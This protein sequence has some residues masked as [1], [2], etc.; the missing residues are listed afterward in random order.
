MGQGGSWRRGSG[1]A[2][3]GHRWVKVAAGGGAAA[4][5]GLGRVGHGWVGEGDSW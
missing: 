1:S 5:L 2:R 3:F 4:R